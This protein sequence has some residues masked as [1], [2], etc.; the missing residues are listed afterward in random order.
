MRLGLKKALMVVVASAG[1]QAVAHHSFI[2][3]FDPEQPLELTGTVTEIEWMN[4]HVWFYID[5]ETEEGATENWG[6]ELGSPNGLIRRGWN[7]NSLQIGNVVNVVG[8]RARDGTQRGAARTVTLST[9]E[10]LFGAQDESR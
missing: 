1:G 7:H 8:V 10:S 6:L 2:A 4:P 3:V 5:V 9:G